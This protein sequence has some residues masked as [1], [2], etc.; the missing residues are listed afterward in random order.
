MSGFAVKPLDIPRLFEEIARV[1]EGRPETG[2]GP[3][4]VGRAVVSS[5]DWE[6]GMALWGDRTRL[7][8][9]IL[10]F[11]D[12]APDK[13]PLPDVGEHADPEALLF[14]LHGLRG[15]AGNLALMALSQ[16]AG[17][18]EDL[19]RA[20]GSLDSVSERLPHLR[21][22]MEVARQAARSVRRS[23]SA[24]PGSEAHAALWADAVAAVRAPLAIAD[25]DLE[26][27]VT[28][29]RTVLASNALDDAALDV[30]CVGLGERG[31]RAQAQA[32]RTAVDAFE[33]ERASQLLESIPAE[34]AARAGQPD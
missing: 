28:A 8:E 26:A 1:L 4:V 9:R 12:E 32:L 5:I 11:L 7:A 13:Y 33:F 31:G 25:T 10:A 16:Q 24:A 27:A 18:L 30:V 2:S 14:S 20:S 34:I 15:A 21:A 23:A 22:L 17:E 19:G 6:R 3:M 29:L